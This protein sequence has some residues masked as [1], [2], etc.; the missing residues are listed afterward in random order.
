MQNVGQVKSFVDDLVMKLGTVSMRVAL[1]LRSAEVQPLF[2]DLC[3][4][5]L[6]NDNSPPPSK[7]TPFALMHLTSNGVL[8]KCFILPIPLPLKA[9]RSSG[10]VAYN[11]ATLQ[12][13]TTT[14]VL[15]GAMLWKDL[16]VILKPAIHS[17][18][19]LPTRAPTAT[20]KTSLVT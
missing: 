12:S 5:L 2:Q 8:F 20:F 16:L 4:Q 19:N 10:L 6:L 15:F 1:V 7:Q 3:I 13:N 17:T 9:V 14:I 11:S 18:I